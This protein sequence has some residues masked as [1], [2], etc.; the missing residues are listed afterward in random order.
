MNFNLLRA[1]RWFELLE[2]R[3]TRR[4]VRRLLSG[5]C[6]GREP[7]CQFGHAILIWFEVGED[8]SR[9]KKDLTVPES[10]QC[11]AWGHQHTSHWDGPA[12]GERARSLQGFASTRY[13]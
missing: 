11:Q 12:S 2:S 4:G 8:L 5:D 3:E 10:T 1:L 13:R 9:A 7:S 6:H